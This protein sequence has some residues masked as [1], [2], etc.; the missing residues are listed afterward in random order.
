[1]PGTNVLIGAGL[2][3]IVALAIALMVVLTGGGGGGGNVSP[4]DVA[5][6]R[7]R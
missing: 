2:V 1:M 5:K 6:V 4:G 3:G 7:P